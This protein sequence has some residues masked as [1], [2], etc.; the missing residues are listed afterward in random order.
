MD[1]ETAVSTYTVSP[2][3]T[4][5]YIVRVTDTQVPTEGDDCMGE[6]TVTVTVNDNPVCEI[7][8]VDEVCPGSV[9]VFS[10]P[11]GE[12]LSY[13]WSISGDGTITGPNDAQT[14]TVEA[15]VACDGGYTL[16]LTVTNANECS[17]DCKKFVS[18]VDDTAPTLVGTFPQGQQA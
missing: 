1:A 11:V 17:S 12:E 16:M 14:V 5:D 4:T 8:G 10:G 13:S 6:S 15:A 3:A 18:V 2:S 9:D 7:T